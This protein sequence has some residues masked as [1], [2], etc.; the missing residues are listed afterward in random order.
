[1]PRPSRASAPLL[2]AVVAS[3]GGVGKVKLPAVRRRSSKFYRHLETGKKE[4]YLI[5]AT[6]G[7]GTTERRGY[8]LGTP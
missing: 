5:R 4:Q 1:M 8:T 6:A 3:A 7:C 2:L